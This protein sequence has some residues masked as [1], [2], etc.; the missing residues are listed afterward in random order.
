MG[1]KSYPVT[2]AIRI[3]RRAKVRFSVHP[4]PYSDHGGALQAAECLQ[5]PPH[6]V[7]KT[8]VMQRKNG[9]PLLVLM[10]GG[11]TVST[12]ALARQIGARK[13]QPC[14]PV[15]AEKLTGYQV[16]GISPFGT[17]TNMPVYAQASI[18]EL[19]RICI[20]AG[21]RG[22]LV[23]LDPAEL[24]RILGVTAVDAVQA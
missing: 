2:A 19:E 14:D 18:L 12:R 9:H 1:H 10:H 20:N 11:M 22:M 24:V 6:Q 15:L 16:G 17:R 5:L 7:I 21:R 4:Y 8:L 3:L 23:E 13:V